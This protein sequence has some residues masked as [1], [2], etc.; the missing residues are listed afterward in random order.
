VTVRLDLRGQQVDQLDAELAERAA[1]ALRLQGELDEAGRA[2]E[3]KQ[4]EFDERTQW[5]LQLKSELD[6]EAQRIAELRS[7]LDTL[8]RQIDAIGD[9]RWI[10][11]G[12]KLGAGPKL[13]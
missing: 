6:S 13:N 4:S 2:L 12:N 8:Q 7:K 9:S 5:A 1:W 10:K 11:L 3:R